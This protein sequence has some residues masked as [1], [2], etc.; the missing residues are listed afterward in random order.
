[1]DEDNLVVFYYFIASEIW[2]GK[3]DCPLVARGAL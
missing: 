2:S 1:M 3:E